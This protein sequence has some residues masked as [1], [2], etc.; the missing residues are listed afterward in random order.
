MQK[1]DASESDLQFTS[2]D[3]PTSSRKFV[4]NKAGIQ[5]KGCPQ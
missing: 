4:S 3:K 1:T 5:Q 2:Q